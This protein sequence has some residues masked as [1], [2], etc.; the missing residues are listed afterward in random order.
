[1]TRPRPSLR[2]EKSLL[3]AGGRFVAGCDEVGRGALAGPVS[4]GMVVVDASAGRVPTGL[5]DSKLLTASRRD[6]LVPV[7]RRWCLASAVGHASPQEVDE[8]GLT[9]ALRL[10]GLRA[11]VSLDIDPDIVL[12]D[13]S[14]DWLTPPPLESERADPGLWSLDPDEGPAVPPYPSL[15]VP[16]IVTQIKAD[17]TCAS[18]AA[19]SVLAKT[20]RDAMMI[21]LSTAH[22]HF[23]WH[24]NKGYSSD[25]HRDELRA[26]GP[27]DQHR[28]SWRLGTVDV[29]ENAAAD[30]EN[31]ATSS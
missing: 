9:Q 31:V 13:G 18:V 1:M 24:E 15:A 26:H 14:F 12:L 29:S 3:R 28:R 6:A 5:A 8:W 21:E 4:V 17:L 7:I 27:C 16:P 10:A 20:T 22:P 25:Q 19:A 30:C 2:R 11:M 23:G